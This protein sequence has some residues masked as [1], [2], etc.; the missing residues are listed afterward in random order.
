MKYALLT[1]N[2]GVTYDQLEEMVNNAMKNF[3]NREIAFIV[4][5]R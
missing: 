5:S 4:P 1:E 2:G 3:Y